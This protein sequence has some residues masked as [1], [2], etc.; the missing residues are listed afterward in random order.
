[1]R[2]IRDLIGCWRCRGAGEI[3]VPGRR[4]AL[5]DLTGPQYGDYLATGARFYATK[6][7]SCPRCDV[8]NGSTAP[9]PA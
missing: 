5:E 7:V 3:V 2:W 6:T 4:I 1:M 8:K 9:D